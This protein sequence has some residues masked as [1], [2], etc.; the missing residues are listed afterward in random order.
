MVIESMLLGMIILFC[1]MLVGFTLLP[2]GI[3]TVISD[4]DPDDKVYEVRALWV[5]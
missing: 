2:V 5:L 3:Y 1:P 4:I